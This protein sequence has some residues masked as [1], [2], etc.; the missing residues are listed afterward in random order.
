V[1]AAHF[2]YATG[3]AR[4]SSGKEATILITPREKLIVMVGRTKLRNTHDAGGYNGGGNR[5]G[6]AGWVNGQQCRGKRLRVRILN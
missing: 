1:S 5:A 3:V 6:G 4:K 2:D